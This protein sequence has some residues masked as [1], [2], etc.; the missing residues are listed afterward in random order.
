MLTLHSKKDTLSS[1]MGNNGSKVK[2]FM[3][4]AK[5]MYITHGHLANM[6]ADVACRQEI[7]VDIGGLE[8]FSHHLYLPQRIMGEELVKHEH[9][10]G[11][12][13]RGHADTC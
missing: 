4:A 1:E 12:S 13:P 9:S 7:R 5:P 11:Q 10:R 8:I 6:A 3:S 2:D